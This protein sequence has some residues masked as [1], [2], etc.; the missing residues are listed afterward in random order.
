MILLT[1]A[2]PTLVALKGFALNVVGHR[3]MVATSASRWMC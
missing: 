2:P 3:P 1:N